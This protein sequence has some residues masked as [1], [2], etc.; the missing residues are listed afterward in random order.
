MDSLQF[1]SD[2]AQAGVQTVL[3]GNIVTVPNLFV[4]LFLGKHPCRIGGKQIE[5][6]EL[7]A[8]ELHLLGVDENLMIVHTDKDAPTGKDIKMALFL[9]VQF[10]ITADQRP[11]A[12]HT[13]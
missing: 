5:Q 8:R 10:R 2:P 12:C 11:A 6:V 13:F 3:G 7:P 1:P 9:P 4:K